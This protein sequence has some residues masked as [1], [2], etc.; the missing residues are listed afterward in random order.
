MAWLAWRRKQPPQQQTQ[1]ASTEYVETQSD[2]PSPLP[3]SPEATLPPHAEPLYARNWAYISEELQDRLAQTTLLT[4][5][6]GL[7]S[8][9]A[10]LAARTGVQR[11]IVADGDVVE[12][13]NL[14][15]QAF[16]RA[17]LGQ[18][19]AEATAAII[20]EIQPRAQ[21]E[22]VPRYLDSADCALLVPHADI[23]LNTI[24]LDTPAF[25]DLNRVARAAQKP[26][27]FPL[28]PAWMG[29]VIVFT[30]ESQSLDEFLGITG[31]QPSAA[32]PS[33][34]EVTLRL[35]ERIYAQVPGGM[36]DD[37]QALI[38][39]YFDQDTSPKVPGGKSVAERGAPQLGLTAHL[40]AA[41]TVRALVALVAQEPVR[42]APQIITADAVAQ[43]AA[44]P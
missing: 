38:R 29:T 37:L 7:G 16:S 3:E 22:V 30:P 41:L 21:V 39:A 11:F 20:K 40:T 8:V 4:A 19:K 2:P 36:P 15:R 13:S 26:V 6:S 23:I 10:A 34:G 31:S 43:A 35:F 24:D 33:P 28:N 42:V 17:H 27:L 1:G 18:N 25:L 5:G 9:V 32:A 44:L 12:E 14:N